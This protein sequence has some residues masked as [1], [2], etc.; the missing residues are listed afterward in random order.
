[1]EEHNDIIWIST[2]TITIVV[3]IIYLCKESLKVT[4]IHTTN[5]AVWTRNLTLK[6]T[7]KNIIAD[8]TYAWQRHGSPAEPCFLQ[9]TPAG[10]QLASF[11]GLAAPFGPSENTKSL[12]PPWFSHP[13]NHYADTWWAKCVSECAQSYSP[14]RFVL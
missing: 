13:C 2:Q 12:G 8:R 6:Y 7:M 10:E 3:H 1:M 5:Q 14:P 4:T 11:Q 9:E